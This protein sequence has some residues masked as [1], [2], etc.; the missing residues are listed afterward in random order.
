MKLD[1][2]AWGDF[3]DGM[4]QHLLGKRAEIEIASRDIG[5]QCE[6]RW[7]PLIGVAYDRKADT[8][9][10]F[11]EGVDHLIMHPTELYAEYGPHGLESVAVVDGQR[12]WQIMLLREPLMLPPATG[13]RRRRGRSAERRH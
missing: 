1:K 5:V 11:L 10:I 2:N 8:L 7:L 3:C 13:S 12:A 9:Q 4:S 6:V